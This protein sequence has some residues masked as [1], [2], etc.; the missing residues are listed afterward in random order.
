MASNLFGSA[1]SDALVSALTLL[2]FDGIQE[3]GLM[4]GSS[5]ISEAILKS[6][7]TLSILTQLLKLTL[8]RLILHRAQEVMLSINDP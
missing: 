8:G 1:D 7:D 3:L 2:D 4:C 5:D 6:T